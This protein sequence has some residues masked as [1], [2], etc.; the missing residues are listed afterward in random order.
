MAVSETADFETLKMAE[1][2]E[3]GGHRKYGIRRRHSSQYDGDPTKEAPEETQNRGGISSGRRVISDSQPPTDASMASSVDSPLSPISPTTEPGP[4]VRFS[5]DVDRP[6]PPRTTRAPGSLEL[7]RPGYIPRE[8]RPSVSKRPGTPT[9]SID[10]QKAISGPAT[11]GQGISRSQSRSVSPGSSRLAVPVEKV[12][13]ASPKGRLRGYSLRRAIFTKNLND[14]AEGSDS[15]IELETAGPSRSQPGSSLLETNGH[16]GRKLGEATIQ[17]SP[18]PDDGSDPAPKYTSKKLQGTSVLPHYQS[19]AQKK[20]RRSGLVGGIRTAYQR[21]RKFILRI[22]DI[23]PSKDGRHIYLD[24]GR[25][26][27]LIDERT[28]KAY[29]GNTVRSS[30]YTL[31]NFL[32]RQLFAQFSKLANFYFLCVSILQM[33]PGLSTTGS[34]TTIIPLLFFVSISM[35]KEGYDDLRRYRLDKAEN[36]KETSVLHAYQPT[37]PTPDEV[38]QALSPHSGVKHWA[39]A[40]WKDIQVGQIIKL[41]RNEA[42]PADLVLLHSE[43]PNGIAYFETMALDGETNLKSKQVAPPLAKR[44]RSIEDITSCDARF[45]V[46]DPNLDL[47]NFEG[48]VEVATETR[49]L[50]NNEIVYRGSILRNTPAAFGMVIYTGEE[51]KIRMNAARNPRIK[52]PTL[53]ATVNRV[54]VMIVIFVICLALFNTVAYQLWSKSTE[55]KSWYLTNAGV[56][57][58]PILTSFIV[59]FNTM[60]PLSLYVSLEIVKLAQMFLLNDI[61]MYDEVSDTPMEAR[62][63][64]INEELGQVSYIFSD[65]TGTLTDNIMQ[66]RKFS[67]AGTAWLHDLDLP[68]AE[69]EANR[70]KL[71]HKKR[72]KGK[73]PDNRRRITSESREDLRS[74]DE[75]AREFAV[76]RQFEITR[77]ASTAS[78][79]RSSARPAKAQAEL[80]SEELLKYLVQKPHTVFARKVRFFLLSIAVCHTCVPETKED[81]EIDFQAASPDELALVKAAQELGFLVVD[82][83]SGTITL[84]TF[85]LGRNA[86]PAFETYEILNV[87][88]FSSKRKRM[89]IIVRLPDRR[90]CIFC[91]GADTI[92]MQR[93][94]QASAAVEKAVQIERRAS[95]RKSMEAQ[96]IIRRNSEQIS[97]RDSMSR[98]SLNLGRSSIGGIGRSSST[99]TRLQPIRDELDTWLRERERDVDYSDVDDESTYH[100]PRPSAQFAGR[101]SFAFS[102]GRASFYGDMYDDLVDEALVVDDSAVLERCLQHINDFATEGLRTLLYAYRF[103]DEQEYTSWK[104]LYSDATTSLVDRQHMIERAGDLIETDLELAGATAIEDKLQ[105]GVPEAIDKLRRAKIKMWMLTGDKRETAINI[106]HSCRLIKDYSSVT[107][108]DHESGHVEQEIAAAIIDINAGRVAHSVVVVDGQTLSAIEEDEAINNLFLDLAVLVESVICCRASPSQKASLVKSIRMKVKKSITLA[109]GDGANDI[110]MIQE[111]HV[112]IGITGKEGLQAARTSDYSI[113]Q[114]RFLLK[115]L[116]VHGRW[117]YIRVCKYTVGTFWKEMLF[118]L[119]QAL[120]QRYAGYTG[121]SLYESVSLSMFNT[122]FTSLPV[123]FMGIFEKDLAA[124]TLLAVPELYTKGQR[125]GGFNI[126]LYL[127]WVFMASSEAMMIFFL[128]LGLYGQAIFVKDNGLYALGD[129]TFTSCIMLIGLKMQFLELH[130]KSITCAIALLLSIGGWFLWNVV[131]SGIYPTNTLYNVKDGLFQRFGTDGLWWLTLVVIVAACLAFEI[132]VTS[133]RATYMPTDVDIFQEYEQDL[134]IRKRFEEAA[135]EELQQGWS[136]GKKKPSVEIDTDAEREGEIQEL[137]D[138]PRVMEQ[139]RTPVALPRSISHSHSSISLG[140]LDR[141]RRRG[142]ADIAEM[143][144]KRFG[145]VRHERLNQE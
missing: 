93:L 102:E 103:L 136:R 133:L 37:S 74:T 45:T 36:N 109:I 54:V 91:K 111:A 65:K 94:K 43:G 60:I 137:L 119:T 34:Y 99:A 46:E 92:V 68:E 35:A 114:F 42:V 32:P 115:L 139:D 51:C 101:H 66:F 6:M 44:C 85:P 10:T 77:N 80:P 16:D 135:S 24:A 41:E 138:Q 121:T 48:K 31:W 61:D 63:S 144:S 67:V 123:I 84:K 27:V 120:F 90:I 75:T 14:Q 143:L 19:W 17:I 131:L 15:E 106:G 23:P 78:K 140:S 28:G 4:R 50:T 40:K 117:N 113:A 2:D 79:W 1:N 83:Q 122:L 116:L 12:S 86:E 11:S 107:V 134:E 95:K 130:N 5:L 64:T 8:G 9:L 33:I 125:R 97:R 71:L 29:I 100:S 39:Q 72:S 59:M 69:I 52:A 21:A 96:Q 76:A 129:L 105:K 47:Y 132:A 145:S 73:R 58:F 82:R 81:G 88:E 18:S 25:K 13:P 110:A 142:S 56:S 57:F 118:Y 112:G 98:P 7:P 53:Q 128:M 22:Q 49:P 3:P 87:I 89:S 126:K 62:T 104:K 30:R 108:L 127:G 124:S 20:S 26:K 55:D 141:A 38:V 70:K